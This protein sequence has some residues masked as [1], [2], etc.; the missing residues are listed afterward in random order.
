MPHAAPPPAEGRG[1][2]LGGGLVAVGLLGALGASALGLMALIGWLLLPDGTQG[3]PPAPEPVA[4]I[5]A[6]APPVPAMLIGIK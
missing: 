1:W 6:P 5:A 3:R 2:L 4:P